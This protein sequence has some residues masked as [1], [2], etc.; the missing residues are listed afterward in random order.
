[1]SAPGSDENGK[2]ALPQHFNPVA[3]HQID[4]D[5]DELRYLVLSAVFKKIDRLIA[6]LNDCDLE[7]QTLFANRAPQTSRRWGYLRRSGLSGG[8]IAWH[9]SFRRGDALR[10]NTTIVKKQVVF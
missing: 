1:L 9:K 4:V 3:L 6:I 7:A 10:R 5:N 8:P 2:T